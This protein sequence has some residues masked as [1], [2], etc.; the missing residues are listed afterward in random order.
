MAFMLLNGSK[1]FKQVWPPQSVSLEY[2]QWCQRLIRQ[3]FWVGVGLAVAYVVFTGLADFYEVFINPKELLKLLELG[4]LTNR[5]GAI[6]QIFLLHKVIF[7]GLL[8][9]LILFW[10][11]PWG[12]RHA[13]LVLILLPW[14]VSFFP[15]V[16]L[17]AFLGLPRSPSAIIFLAQVLLTPVYWWLHLI[18]QIVPLLFYFL[19]YP[20]IGL[21]KLG[22][23]SIYSLTETTEILFV[24]I[25][26]QVGVYLYEQSKQS[27]LEATRQL[28]LCFHSITHD[29]RTPVMG[30]LMLLR[31]I[32][33]N[34]PAQQS[35]QLTQLELAHLIQGNDRLLDLMDSL[36]T[37]QTMAQI[38]FALRPQPTQLREIVVT[39]LQDLQPALY[40]HNAMISNRIGADLP[41]LD[42][43]PQQVRR[44]FNNL[45]SNAITHNPPDVSLKLEAF[46][47]KGE[48]RQPMIKVI[49]EDNGLGIPLAQ[50]KTLFEPYTRGQN[51]QY[52]PGLGLGLYIC[53]QIILAHGGNIGVKSHSQGTLFWFTLP[54]SRLSALAA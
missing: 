22:G 1:L 38:N 24:C 40:K 44:V 37:P 32:Q 48:P 52:L 12:R 7:F 6:H 47:I 43:D 49:V 28:K 26:C 54:I 11:S 33:Q 51:T 15:E 3:R 27:E 9:L 4:N 2:R 8:I 45:I 53:R 20:L 13:N 10:K 31:S 50:Q 5:L 41:I 34:T 16:V 25:T 39:V 35:A 19:V 23:I 46:C 30:S 14:T 42:I 17:G 29:L 36:L 18:A 21:T